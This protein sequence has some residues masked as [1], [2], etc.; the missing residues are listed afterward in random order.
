[1]VLLCRRNDFWCPTLYFYGLGYSGTFNN[2]FLLDALRA[3]DTDEVI[4]KM[5]GP[6][7]PILIIPTQGDSFIFLILPVRLKAEHNS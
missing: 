2:R 4:L 3:S 5:N 6:V 1:M 7:A